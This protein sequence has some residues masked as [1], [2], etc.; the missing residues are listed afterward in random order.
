MANRS[1]PNRRLRAAREQ[2]NMTQLQLAEL[3]DMDPRTIQRWES[4]ESSPGAYARELLSKHLR[5]TPAELGLLIHDPE[6]ERQEENDEPAL[7]GE[8][9][10][11]SLPPQ[12]I[13]RSQTMPLSQ[14]LIII[15]GSLAVLSQWTIWWLTQ[16]RRKTPPEARHRARTRPPSQE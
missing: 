12:S 4:G 13:E 7:T 10:P 9:Q 2:R 15:I 14:W 1:R 8:Q 5:A 3:I 6:E 11:A 16:H